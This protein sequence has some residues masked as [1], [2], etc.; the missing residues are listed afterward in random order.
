MRWGPV[1]NSLE[2][3]T[4]ERG[5]VAFRQAIGDAKCAYTLV[6]SQHPDR[7]GPVGAPHAALKAERIEDASKRI[8]DVCVREG[9]VRQRARPADFTA[10]FLWA[11]SA[12]N[13]GRLANG[14]AGAGGTRG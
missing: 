12:S 1:V 6:V 5:A 8:P 4:H 11:A 2:R 10:T 7:S 9:V 14:S 13:L 3:F